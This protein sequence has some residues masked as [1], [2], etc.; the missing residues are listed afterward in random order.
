MGRVWGLIALLMC[1][2][3][4]NAAAGKTVMLAMLFAYP[5]L[6]IQG[7]RMLMLKLE[8]LTFCVLQ[9][10]IQPYT[11]PNGTFCLPSDGRKQPK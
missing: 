9:L 7:T 8:W 11:C 5:F 10:L 4:A 2:Y 6:N 3:R 1:F